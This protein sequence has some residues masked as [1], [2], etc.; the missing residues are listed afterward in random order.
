MLKGDVVAIQHPEQT[1][2]KADLVVHVVLVHGN[3]RES[4]ASG[5][6]REHA[7]ALI[8]LQERV[9]DD[10]CTLIL[11]AVGVAY[12]DRNL[13]TSYGKDRIF[14][15]H[16]GPHIAQLAQ[17]G[18]RDHRDHLGVIHNAR[19]RHEKSA[20]VSPVFV[21]VRLHRAGDDCSGDVAAAAG[22]GL[23]AAV[24][25]AAVETR[26]DDVLRIREFLCPLLRGFVVIGS[27]RV[28]ADELRRV[29][30]IKPE[31]VRKQQPAEVFP[32]ACNIVLARAG[33]DVFLDRREFGGDVR[34][35]PKIGLDGDVAF[36]DLIIWLVKGHAVGVLGIA[37]IE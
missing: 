4:F 22:E 6:A 29:V 20:H 19:V 27:V 11:R 13:R 34:L 10:H 5:D 23:D 1:I 26:H 24:A 35:E 7:F 2:T 14:V 32:A 21:N 31:K 18:I 16:G 9:G 33:D 17:L 28:E 37:K 3:D 25:L 36:G 8:I 12:I 30:K 15:Q